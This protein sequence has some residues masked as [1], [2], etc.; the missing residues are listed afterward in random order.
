[1]VITI[2]MRVTDNLIHIYE[3]I[4]CN[5]IK[6]LLLGL[7]QSYIFQYFILLS[8]QGVSIPPAQLKPRLRV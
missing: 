6:L 2:F 4:L 8:R 3:K 1:M 7:S 5:I